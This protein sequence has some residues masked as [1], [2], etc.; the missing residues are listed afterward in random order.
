MRIKQTYHKIGRAEVD[1]QQLETCLQSYSRP[2][3]KISAWLR[4]GELIRI[5]KGL[6]VFSPS[7]SGGSY[8]LPYLANLIYGPSVVSLQVKMLL[9]LLTT[10]KE[11]LYG[12]RNFFRC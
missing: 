3:D 5:K 7:I 6:Y 1:Y 8:S 10:N 9:V 11:L 12:R 4:T 2:R